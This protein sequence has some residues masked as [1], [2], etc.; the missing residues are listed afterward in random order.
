MFVVEFPSLLIHGL[1]SGA[2]KVGGHITEEFR[3]GA[4]LQEQRQTAQAMGGDNEASRVAHLLREAPP[5]PPVQL[6]GAIEENAVVTREFRTES[7]QKAAGK[8][9]VGFIEPQPVDL[10]ANAFKMVPEILQEGS[11]AAAMRADDA[12]PKVQVF[13]AV[14]HLVPRA[15][16]WTIADLPH[17]LGAK[18]IFARP[19]VALIP[20]WGRSRSISLPV[21]ERV[22][23]TRSTAPPGS[24]SASTAQTS[25]MSFPEKL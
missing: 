3:G 12:P 5:F 11:F 2:E 8:A 25:E 14:L 6:F 24:A 17:Q 23:S 7:V 22:N 20:G 1:R 16:E 10:E 15:F 4:A 19:H 9:G 13:Q 18:W 21:G